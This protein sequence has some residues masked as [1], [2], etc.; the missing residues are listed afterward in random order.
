MDQPGL[1][2]GLHGQALRALERINFLSD[3]AGILWRPIRG[4]AVDSPRPLRVLDLASGAGDVPIRLWHKARRSGLAIDVAG[5]D[6]S[7]VAVRHAE[8]RAQRAGANVRFFECDLFGDELPEGY[9]VL[10]CSLFLH[11]LDDDPAVFL[12]G[13][14]A[15]AARR[16]VLINDLER[17]R[18]G[19]WLAWLGTRVLTMSSV[20]RVDGPR[21][22]EGAY[23]VEEARRL[24]E[25]A[26]LVGVNVRRCWPC[27]YL[28]RWVKT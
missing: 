28:L 21:S 1:D 23:T 6:V 12:L 11:H 22:V 5:C 26:G 17:S 16:A 25:R 13:A 18:L 19:W 14:M 10:T 8:E 3:S 7:P 2:G 9:D 27:R 24:A 4:L 20:A 15:K